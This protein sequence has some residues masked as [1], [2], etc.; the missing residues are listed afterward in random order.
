MSQGVPG[1]QHT[2]WNTV[3]LGSPDDSA[4]TV[5]RAM[6]NDFQALNLTM[7]ARLGSAPL[8]ACAFCLIL[9]LP[10]LEREW[11]D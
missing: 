5:E 9:L 1:P 4:R 2:A 7:A 6:E 3:L 11:Y 8:W 10:I